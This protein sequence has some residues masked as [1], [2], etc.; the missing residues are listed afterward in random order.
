MEVIEIEN[1]F[2]EDIGTDL[3]SEIVEHEIIEQDELE[4]EEEDKLS[5]LGPEKRDETDNLLNLYLRE[6]APIPLLN[7]QDE[8]KYGKMVKDGQKLEE[9]MK[10]LEKEYGHIPSLEQLSKNL[11]LTVEDVKRIQKNAI[12]ASNKLVTSNLRLVVSIAKKYK[13]KG[14]PFDDLIQEGNMGLIRAVEKFDPDKGYKFSTYAT[15]WIR[16]AISRG[17]SIKS[18]SIRLPLHIVEASQ[19][20]KKAI[21]R[22]SQE[23]GKRPN[24]DILAKELDITVDKLRTITEASIEPI[25]LDTKL[26]GDDDIYVRD[27]V[28]G[29][30]ES[31][32]EFV[33]KES[34]KENI[35]KVLDVLTEKEKEIIKFRF[36]ILDGHQ[37]SLQ[38]IG[39][40]YGLTRERVRQILN[41]AMK[42]L[43]HSDKLRALSGFLEN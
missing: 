4:S 7:K 34:L 39:D 43:R 11:N 13:E 16:Q 14:L 28:P 12:N 26:K 15:W 3:S 30:E 18:R 27:I 31:P 20:I 2:E 35:E 22:L 1:L 42:K 8:I 40:F 9:I 19:K 21:R 23:N 25:S 37:K 33:L 29:L 38:E 36:G 5:V 6:I 24:N 41:Q 17:L 10:I 32:E